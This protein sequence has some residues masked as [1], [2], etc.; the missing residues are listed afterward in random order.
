MSEFFRRYV[1]TCLCIVYGI[2]TFACGAT[3]QT[4]AYWI[5]LTFGALAYFAGSWRYWP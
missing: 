4:P 1:F 5:G 2:V 3:F